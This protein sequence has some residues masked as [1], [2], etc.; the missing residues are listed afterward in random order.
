MSSPNA[1]PTGPFTAEETRRLRA[2]IDRLR[3]PGA[4]RPG[5]WSVSPLN[6]DPEVTGPVPERIRLR[7]TTLRS[8]GTMPGVFAPREDTHAFL[9]ALVAS[10]VPSIV[11][12]G[13]SGRADDEVRE[14]LAAIEAANPDCVAVC[15]FVT[16]TDDADRA[17]RLGYHAVQIPV[18]GFGPASLI[19][20]SSIYPM[21]WQGRDWRRAVTARERA[22]FVA[23]A[24]T[25][26]AHARG[27]GLRV[28]AST[29]MVSF[30]SPEMLAETV[31]RLGAAGAGEITLFDGPGSL[32]PEAFAR[33]VRDV[34][35][36]A[37][38]VEVGLHPHNAFG[39]A[40]AC[41]VAAANAGADVVEAS[42]NGYCGGPG[43]A[44]LAVTAAAFE[45]VYGVRTG[46]RLQ[47]LT[48]L[49]RSAEELTGYRVAWNH[50]I[51][52]TDTF[53]WGGG[54]WIAQ[55]TE[56]DPL[57]HNSI[58]PALVGNARLLP[59]TPQSG[60]YAMAATLRRLGV[61]VDPVNVPAVL[62]RCQEESRARR[63]LLSDEE[64]REIA[65]HSHR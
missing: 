28:I 19:Y 63:R 44:D 59:L 60:A 26:V 23:R 43:N 15:P 40:V 46:I 36:A 22:D 35:S 39:L 50:P 13:L 25:V 41:A 27:S 2:D 57:L 48:A 32:G 20:E 31:T 55:E 5:R 62:R 6:R 30:A 4:Y 34:K 54:D 37:P 10:G 64:I 14:D 56:I 61:D 1:E 21:A 38:D 3:A 52:G 45:A 8:A 12:A 24:A 9:R 18:A 7:D 49:A 47:A 53:C 11:T 17:H 33:L 16:T 29:M 65:R 51:T 58:E 42:V